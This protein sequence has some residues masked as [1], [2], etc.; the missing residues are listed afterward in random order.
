[1]EKYKTLVLSGNSTNAIVMLGALQYLY[2]NKILNT[3]QTF[4]AASSGSILSLLLAIGYT[5][6]EVLSYLCV[7]KVYKTVPPFNI[8]NVLL[9]GKPLMEF[10][11][12]KKCLEDMIC[13][14]IG[15]IPTLKSFL[16]NFN[17]TIIF[18]VFNLTDNKLEYVSY[19]TYPDLKLTDAVHMSCNFPIMFTPFHYN[20]K[21]YIDGGLADNFPID[22]ALKYAPEPIIGVCLKNPSTQYTP[23][24]SRFAIF[25]LLKIMFNIHTESVLEEKIT[26][27]SSLCDIVEIEQKP[28]F[29]N[30]NSE[31]KHLIDL[32]DV[33]YLKG[34]Q[35]WKQLV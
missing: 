34:K 23:E 16:T 19:K 2:D 7:N 25:E 29:F 24:N 6:L 20:N 26:R 35:S 22:Y 5:P 32:F 10:T 33:G 11:P 21:Y 1:M 30:F 4:V 28:N 15:H 13:D 18:S 12:I 9:S 14:K 8:A 31:N 27:C 3:I 17:I